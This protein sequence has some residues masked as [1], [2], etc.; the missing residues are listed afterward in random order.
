MSIA[1]EDSAYQI[2]TDGTTMGRWEAGKAI[3]VVE[4]VR[5]EV[6]IQG[7][8]QVNICDLSLL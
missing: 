2:M 3:E 5:I 4:E 6:W 7:K 8:G 1:R